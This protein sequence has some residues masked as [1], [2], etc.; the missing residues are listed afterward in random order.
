M[1]GSVSIFGTFRFQSLRLSAAGRSELALTR[2]LA[3]K[4]SEA[5]TPDKRNV[6]KTSGSLTRSLECSLTCEICGLETISK[7]LLYGGPSLITEVSGSGTDKGIIG[8]FGG[9]F[10]P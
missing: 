5:E 6:V 4:R 2:S 10:L 7:Q 9:I 8:D 3:D 1:Q